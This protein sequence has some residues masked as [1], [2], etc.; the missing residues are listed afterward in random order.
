[1]LLM[2]V[3]ITLSGWFGFNTYKAYLSYSSS[4]INTRGSSFVNQIDDFLEELA[5]EESVS[6]IYFGTNGEKGFEKLKSARIAVD[7]AFEML[8]N[9]SD[10]NKFTKFKQKIMTIKDDL[11]SARSK[12][13]TLNGTFKDIIDDIYYQKIFLLLQK[14][15]KIIA[16]SEVSDVIK[17]NLTLSVDYMLPQGNIKLEKYLILSKILSKTPML[18]IEVD[19]WNR[20]LTNEYLPDVSTLKVKPTTTANQ[21]AIVHHISYPTVNEVMSV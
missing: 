18:P 16:K 2:M 15:A 6:A 4:Q 13:D 20:A 19:S 5:H 1:M 8:L 9:E 3:M 14:E 7:N 11:K 10:K 21:T 12:V 17:T